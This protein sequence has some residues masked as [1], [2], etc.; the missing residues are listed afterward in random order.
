MTALWDRA[1][2]SALR[3]VN[4]RGR[5]LVYGGATHVMGILNLTPD[6][7]ADGGQFLDTEKA[8]A[9]ARAMAAAGAAIIDIGAESAGVSA[10][11]PALTEELGRLLPVIR[12]LQELPVLISVDT[13]KGR[14]ATAVLAAGAHIIN[15]ISGLR[16]DEGLA[17]VIADHGAGVVIM[18]SLGV[19]PALSRD[20]RYDDVVSAVCRGLSEGSERALKAGIARERIIV[21][22]GIGVGKRTEHN[23][24]L[25]RSLG[26]IGRLGFPVLVGASRTS[27]IGNVLG[28]PIADRD[29]GTLATTALAVAQGADLVRVHAVGPN[30]A[31]AR[32]ADAIVRG[33]TAPPTG[34]PYD[35]VTGQPRL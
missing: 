25:L 18:H 22:P 31:A 4:Y 23:L 30:V 5:K 15:D 28:V 2:A 13:Y 3:T 35:E 9:R 26:A 24:T 11:R 12:G 20:P 14:V 27:V 33:I 32:M 16:A 34:W 7:F 17:A 6:S 10:S 8:L 19:P 21:D 29:T 1:G